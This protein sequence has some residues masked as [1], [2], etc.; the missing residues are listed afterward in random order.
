MADTTRRE[1]LKTGAG[2]ALTAGAAGAFAP[3]VEYYVSG[4]TGAVKE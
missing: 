4:M 1:L 3:F 2:V